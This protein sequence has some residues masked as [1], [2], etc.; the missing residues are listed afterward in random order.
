MWGYISMLYIGEWWVHFT[1]EQETYFPV[2]EGP[3]VGA[4]TEKEYLLRSEV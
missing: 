4:M 1:S 2:S 3:T